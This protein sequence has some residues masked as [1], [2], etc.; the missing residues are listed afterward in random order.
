MISHQLEDY[1]VRLSKPLLQVNGGFNSCH[2]ISMVE[3]QKNV[4]NHQPIHHNLVFP[5]SNHLLC[6]LHSSSN[7][8][9]GKYSDSFHL[10]LTI[11]QKFGHT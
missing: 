1:L 6:K 11:R 3:Q 10:T 9:C 8:Y 7:F 2:P 4:C 5:N